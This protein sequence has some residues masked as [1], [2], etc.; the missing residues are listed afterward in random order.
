M[1]H[2]W[3]SLV[4]ELTLALVR[5][6][7]VNGTPDEACFA[8]QFHAL[9]AARPYYSDHP[10]HVWREHIP[11][12]PHGRENVYALVRGSG[13]ST[14]VLTGHYDVV[15]IGNYGSLAPWA[16]DPE[17]LLPRLIEQL[18]HEPQSDVLALADLRSGDFLPGR[19]VLDMKSGLAIGIA[20]Q[21]RFAQAAET[22]PGNILLI[23]TPDEEASSY[24][25]RGAAQR[26]PRLLGDYDLDPVVAINLDVTVDRGDGHDGQAIFLGSVGKVLPAVY[27]AGR[28]THAGAP[29]DG[30]NANLIAAELTRR[31]ECNVELCDVGEGEAAP[32]PVSLTQIDLKQHYDVTT[33]AAAWCAYN[34][35]THGRT[36]GQILPIMQQLV[37][38]A[39]DA[40]ITSLQEQARRFE[41]LSG[42]PVSTPAWQP[43]VYTFAELRAL[44]LER[45]GPAATEAVH[46]LASR[47]ENDPAVDIPTFS[48]RVIELLW[49]A[50]GLTGPAAVIAFASLYYPPVHVNKTSPRQLRLHACVERQAT[51]FTRDTAVPIRL[52]QFFPGISDMSFLG[53]VEPPGE[54]AVMANN[55]PAWGTRIRYDYGVL[56]TLDLPTINIGPW[57]RDY[58]QRTERVYTP[59]A[60]AEVPELI[61]RIVADLL[62]NSWQY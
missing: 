29:F 14:V 46:A 48:R 30:V 57:G 19:G 10:E 43:Q 53:C 45:G 32:P 34:V 61:W 17:A 25:M 26:L 3:Y 20:I 5:L 44:A 40:T 51:A 27:I 47:L 42:L 28:E 35:L 41:A 1:P 39:L 58:H 62:V 11:G 55:T 22:L 15:D 24:G 23:A 9:L 16:F 18:E 37:R 31:I 33:P 7:S 50:S 60:F 38:E 4:R 56:Q 13:Q 21:E 8:E 12:D 52:R 59:Y 2:D 36:A 49:A 6:P 54:L